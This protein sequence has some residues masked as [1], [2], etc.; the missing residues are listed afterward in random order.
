MDI[1][2][3]FPKG[4]YPVPELLP[5]SHQHRLQGV[6]H[7]FAIPIHNLAVRPSCDCG[8]PLAIVLHYK[9]S[10]RSAVSSA[11]GTVCLPSRVPNSP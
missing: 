4:Q 6:Y 9:Q 8:D 1:Y 5:I 2:P 7:A 10:P 3:P 11:L